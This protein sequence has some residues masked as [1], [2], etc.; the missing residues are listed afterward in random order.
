MRSKAE[1]GEMFGKFQ[2]WEERQ[3]GTQIKQV[4]SD[5]GLEF[6]KLAKNLERLGIGCRFSAPYQQ[7]GF[8]ERRHR[9]LVDTALTML[10]HAEIPVTYWDYAVLTATHAY[11]R[12]PTRTLNNLSP[13]EAL[14]QQPPDYEKH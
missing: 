1:V 12:S 2:V 8:V 6:K 5:N 10:Q 7:M 4:Q 14:F 11:N 3:C 13:Y 9:H